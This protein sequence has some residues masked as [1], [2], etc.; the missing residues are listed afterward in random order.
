ME[1]PA[2]PGTTDFVNR[3]SSFLLNQVSSFKQLTNSVWAST[4]ALENVATSYSGQATEYNEL[5]K[6]MLFKLVSHTEPITQLL[7]NYYNVTVMFKFF[8]YQK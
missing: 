7:L 2:E 1:V 4:F 5:I 6:V 3:T 8:Q